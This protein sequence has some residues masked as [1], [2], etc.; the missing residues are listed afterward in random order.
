MQPWRP[1]CA[2]ASGLVAVAD[3]ASEEDE[4]VEEGRASVAFGEAARRARS[5]FCV[6][7]VCRLC[8][9]HVQPRRAA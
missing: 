5:V 6:L 3:R 4:V 1:H 2:E 7:F 9:T 8:N